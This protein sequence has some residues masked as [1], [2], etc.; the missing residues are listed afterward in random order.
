MRKA[1]TR[2]EDTLAFGAT[3]TEKRI[4]EFVSVALTINRRRLE[5]EVFPG[6]SLVD[7]V[8]PS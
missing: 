7:A 3:A 4:V 8:M 1:S 6:L 5:I 2:G